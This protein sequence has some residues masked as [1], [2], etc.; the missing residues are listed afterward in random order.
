MTPYTKETGAD[1]YKQGFRFVL[2][3]QYGTSR[4]L[5]EYPHCPYGYAVYNLRSNGDKGDCVG[6]YYDEED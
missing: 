6:Y 2:C 1:L 3:E 4:V 5:R